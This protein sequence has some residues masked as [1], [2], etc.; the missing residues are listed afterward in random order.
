MRLDLS[1]LKSVHAFA[2]AF[3]DHL[4]VLVNNAGIMAMPH[5]RETEDGFETV[6]GVC[7]LGHF[8]SAAIEMLYKSKDASSA[9]SGST[10]I[11]MGILISRTCTLRSASTASGRPTARRS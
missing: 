10:R 1:S 7:H 5:H 9:P 3:H 8:C 4:D 11:A 6:I 2:D